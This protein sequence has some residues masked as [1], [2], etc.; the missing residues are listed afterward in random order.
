MKRRLTLFAAAIAV[1]FLVFHPSAKAAADL[2]TDAKAAD[3]LS[4][5]LTY[6]VDRTDASVAA[7]QAYLQQ[8][9]KTDAYAK[10]RPALVAPKRMPF[11]DVFKG[12]M[13]F[14]KN[15]GGDKY[16][17]PALNE[18]SPSEL[19]DELT[20]LQSYNVQQ[21][22]RLNQQRDACDSMR[23]Y[24]KSIGEFEKYMKWAKQNAPGAA[25]SPAAA[26][27]S[28]PPT[29]QEAAARMEALVKYARSI[30]WKKAQARGTSEADF[31]RQWQ[32]RV[33]KYKEAVADKV[34][35]VRGLSG[36]LAKSE[37]A[38]ANAQPS[39]TLVPAAAPQLG[40]I[41]PPA[42]WSTTGPP[43][44]QAAR[45][46]PPPV[47]SPDS[48]AHFQQVDGQN[49]WNPWDGQFYDGGVPMGS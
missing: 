23:V 11:T 14:V 44:V 6:S 36:A 2:L 8:I 29:P 12:A 34:E 49:A 27:Q 30:A 20:E 13:L 31:D 10:E 19:L 38:G 41:P 39:L 25:Q 18:R 21:F 42:I 17:D 4:D 40:P 35:G 37:V 43:P 16:A 1:N 45:A 33:A 3:V 5:L 46:L 48:N 47:A 32:E 26:G 22:V 24:L 7:M 28:A 9:G 15:G